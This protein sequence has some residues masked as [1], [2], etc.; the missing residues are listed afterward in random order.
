MDPELITLA[1]RLG[2]ASAA[3]G[4]KISTAESCTG[5]LIAAAITEVPG[6]SAWFD[7]GFVTYSNRA[8]TELLKVK[9]ET[10]EQFG[11]VSTETAHEM[12]AG[13]LANSDAEWVIAVTGVAGPGG[14][15]SD[16]PVGTVYIAW[17]NKHK[18]LHVE[19]FQFTGNRQQVRRQTA[20]TALSN[21]IDYLCN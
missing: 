16:K 20:V 21:L 5:G 12:A 4:I 19:R 13:A 18:F 1:E 7:R 3:L 15:G 9:P 11:A 17:Q 8:K 14:G 2:Q 6:S 10:L